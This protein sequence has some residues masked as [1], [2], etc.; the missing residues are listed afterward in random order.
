MHYF[1]S[2]EKEVLRELKTTENGLSQEEAKARLQKY[3]ENKL[4]EEE[5][6]GP[7]KIF[8]TQ[9]KSSIIWILI[10]AMIISGAAKEWTDFWVIFAIIILN[11]IL[12]FLQEYKAEKAIDALKQIMSP[13]AKV[14]R[15]G[16]EQMIDAKEIVP[17]DLILLETGDKITADARIIQTTHF[18]VQ[19]AA[20]TGE[21]IP[22]KKENIALKENTAV[23]DRKNMTFAGTIATKGHAKAIVTATGM[24][25]E[26][27]KIAGMIQE[28]KSPPTPLQKKLKHLGGFLAVSVVLIAVLIFLYGVFITGNDILEML[29]AAIAIAVAAIPEGLPAVV[30]ISLA[31]GVQRMASKNALIRK[32]PSAETLGACTVIC[33]DKTGTLTHNEM[34]VRKIYANRETIN[35]YGSGYSPEGKFSKNPKEFELL[36]QIG[37]LNNN[38]KLSQK[39]EGWDVIG[40]PTEA[41]LL[42]SAKKA[43]I[44]Y[45]KLQD[46]YPRMDEIE[47]SSERKLMTTIHKTKNHGIAMIKGAP[48]ILIKKCNRILVNNHIERLTRKEKE[49]ILEKNENLTKEALRVLGFAYKDLSGVDAKGEIEENLIFVGLQGMIDP[50]RKEAKEAIKKC[51]DAGIKVVMI[52]GDHIGTATS[53]A[54]E[55]GITGKAIT[56][57]ELEKIENLKEHVEE[58]GIYARVN[59]EHKVK[60]VD[61]F[62]ETDHVTA[63]TGDGVND[64]PALKKADIGIAMGITGTDVAKEASSM[65]LADDN[66]ASIVNAVEEGRRIFDNIKKFVEYLLS[67]NMGEVLTVFLAIILKLPLPI[68][69]LQ[70]LWIN[71]VT[72]GAPALALSIEPAEPE[73]MK[74]KPRKTEEK[75]VNKYRGLM[76]LSIGLIMMAGTLFIFDSHLGQGLAYAQTLAFS[77]LMMFQMFN[78]LNQRSED[79]SLFQ[80]GIFKNKWMLAAIL[81]SVLFQIA[82]VYV[83]FLQELFGT[84]AIKALDWIKVI[85]ISST[86]F[87]FAEIIKLIKRR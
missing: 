66:F 22:V 85:G 64:A 19:E 2:E 34:T 57:Q 41:A 39:N 37:A 21:S 68:T 25:T 24:K 42:A 12:G 5:K 84:T 79:L 45:E 16:K 3:G 27:G 28:T 1:S 81:S 78:V 11:A 49:E 32:L 83:P 38:A 58:I 44:D 67:S 20:L 40:D 50:P 13:K 23:A 69:A 52:T 70:I 51:N 4:I 14:I 73:I 75:I 53:I 43:G 86:V 48:E 15:D 17:G 7:I 62:K 30:T 9:F 72:D 10:I 74:R 33:S 61:A 56:G 63:M 31:M 80:I 6:T 87:I 59:P 47:F 46:K 8:L 60:I 71:L 77:T 29:L 55:L 36:L 82:V 65:I 35:V 54:R 26:I 18:E 76:I